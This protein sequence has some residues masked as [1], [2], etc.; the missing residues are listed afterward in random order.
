MVMVH[1]D[2]KGLVLPP[3]VACIQVC[4]CVCVSVCTCVC[5]RVTCVYVYVCVCVCVCVYMCVCMWHLTK[6]S[7][8]ACLRI[9][10]KPHKNPS[11]NGLSLKV[12]GYCE[13]AWFKNNFAKVFSACNYYAGVATTSNAVSFRSLWSKSVLQELVRSY[14]RQVQ[15][16]S[17]YT[18]QIF[19]IS[20]LKLC[21]SVRP[22]FLVYSP[23]KYCWGTDE[24][25]FE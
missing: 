24:S 14:L 18:V 15:R 16:C 10:S 3:R 21:A 13:G 11:F 4:A 2:N 1:G 19:V 23:H 6:W 20:F 25:F 8:C 9:T 17:R 12:T 5:V 22:V 7:T